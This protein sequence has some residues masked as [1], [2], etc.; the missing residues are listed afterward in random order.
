MAYPTKRSDEIVQEILERMSNGEPMAQICRDK[1]MPHPS[2]WADWCLADQALSIAHTRARDAGHDAIAARLRET[3]RGTGESTGDV[4]R[5]KLIID[6]D[7]KLLAKWDPKRYGDKLQTEHSGSLTI[8]AEL[9]AKKLAEAIK[10]ADD[11][12]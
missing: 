3:A 9:E 5:D 10:A 6:T 12:I 8:N 2:T 4:A 1:K 7:L 11:D